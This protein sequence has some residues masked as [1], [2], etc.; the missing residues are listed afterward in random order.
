MKGEGE[1]PLLHH[2]GGG[3]EPEQSQHLT[4]INT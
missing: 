2:D 3:P 4:L 1:G